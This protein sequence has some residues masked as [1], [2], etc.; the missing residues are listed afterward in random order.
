MFIDVP[1]IAAETLAGIAW[2]LCLSNIHPASIKL[3]AYGIIISP[4]KLIKRLRYKFKY[5]S[6]SAFNDAAAALF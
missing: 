5:S 2:H 6:L 1:V 3:S 4:E